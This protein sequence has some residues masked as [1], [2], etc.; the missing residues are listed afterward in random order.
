[1]RLLR[2]GTGGTGLWRHRVVVV[3]F[4]VLSC[5]ILLVP[6][7]SHSLVPFVS[8]F[9]VPSTSHSLVPFVSHSFVPSVSLF[10]S[11]FR[12]ALTH[13]SHECEPTSTMN[14]RVRHTRRTRSQ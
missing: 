8:H 10:G 3:R 9:L 4:L 11:L 13:T 7:V 14:H 5:V 1:M 2:W 12:F 6:F